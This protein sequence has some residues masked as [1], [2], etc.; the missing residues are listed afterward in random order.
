MTGV[1]A[2]RVVRWPYVLVFFTVMALALGATFL[3]PY[4]S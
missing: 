1:H 4:S 2:R 3:E